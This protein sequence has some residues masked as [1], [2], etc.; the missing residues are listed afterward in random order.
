MPLNEICE[1]ITSKR[2]GTTYYS[3][4]TGYKQ[5]EATTGWWVPLQS[6]SP[7]LSSILQK[8]AFNKHSARNCFNGHSS[9]Y[10]IFS[11][12][13]PLASCF[14]RQIFMFFFSNFGLL[15]FCC[16]VGCVS[17]LTH[18]LYFGLSLLQVISFGNFLVRT[19]RWSNIDRTWCSNNS[20]S[21]FFLLF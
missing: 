12:I 19:N 4:V 18:L 8:H 3:P 1:Q 10:Q 20:W 6:K 5:S 15:L 9:L 17:N 14:D 7:I 11:S 2:L 21:N 13:H 16:T